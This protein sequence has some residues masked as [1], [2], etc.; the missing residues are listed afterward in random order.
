[1][2]FV[3]VMGEIDISVGSMVGFLA[4]T[5]GICAS[6]QHLGLSAGA[7]AFI[8][9]AIGTILGWVNGLLVAYG[10]VPSIIVT[11]GMLTVLREVTQMLMEGRWITDLP[12]G[13]RFYGTGSVLASTVGIGKGA[14]RSSV[15]EGA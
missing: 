3:V 15:L 7:S 11:L 12:A 13:L 8:T 14:A 10:R 9:C 5:V 1:M 2:T 6:G 4:A